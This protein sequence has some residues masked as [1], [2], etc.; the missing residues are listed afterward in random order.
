MTKPLYKDIEDKLIDLSIQF[1]L[2]KDLVSQANEKHD[3]VEEGLMQYHHGKMK[4]INR[5][6]ADFWKM[7]YKGN[8]IQSIEIKSDQE[9]STSSARLRSYNYRIVLKTNDDTE[10]DMR[11]R[12]SAGQRVL[13]SIIIRLSLAET[14]CQNCGILAL[15]EPTTNLDA[16][17]IEGLAR[18]LIEIIESRKRQDS[19][20]LIVITHDE[21]FVQLLGSAYTEF[22]WKVSKDNNYYSRIKK[23][24]I[25]SIL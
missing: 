22:I 4:E 24:S 14:F 8:D 2:S 9:K 17:N 7:T 3:S 20:Q 1:N 23:L 13:S 18:S 16:E 19:F 21:Q 5:Q 10:L 6:L 15:D 25:K 11:G 12:C